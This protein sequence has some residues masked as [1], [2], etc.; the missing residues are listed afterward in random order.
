[1]SHNFYISNCY[2]I[3]STYECSQR[4]YLVE[5]PKQF[6]IKPTLVLQVTFKFQEKNK[7]EILESVMYY[8]AKSI[9]QFLLM[10]WSWKLVP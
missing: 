2:K 8:L 6:D 1:M 10:L 4:N 9:L 5:C 7:A 3:Q